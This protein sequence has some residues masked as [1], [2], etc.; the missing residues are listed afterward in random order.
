MK[1]ITNY[2]Y[3][4]PTP[5]IQKDFDNLKKANITYVL[6]LQTP[7][8]MKT[9]KIDDN[10]LQDI[11]KSLGIK[12][13]QIPITDFIPQDLFVKAFDTIRLLHQVIWKKEVIALVFKR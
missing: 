12:Y 6:N 9:N 4:G 1:K 11:Y 10:T 3:I 7:K 5:E 2:L 8:E 13:K